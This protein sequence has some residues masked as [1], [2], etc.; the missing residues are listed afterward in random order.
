[1]EVP[2]REEETLHQKYFANIETRE[3]L[4]PA[5]TKKSSSDGLNNMLKKAM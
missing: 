4:M 5:S 3:S 2:K 1:M